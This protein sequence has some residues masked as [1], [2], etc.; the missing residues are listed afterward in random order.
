MK[1]NRNINSIQDADD[2]PIPVCG[3]ATINERV[4]TVQARVVKPVT[5]EPCK[6]PLRLRQPPSYLNYYEVD[7][8]STDVGKYVDYCYCIKTPVTY[9]DA[10]SCPKANQWKC[11]MDN[12]FEML[13]LN[14]T[15]VV[16]ELPTNKSIVGED[17]FII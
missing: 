1:F 9:E 6:Y 10:V 15:F 17:G 8:E 16:T 5:D 2:E 7:A 13:Q 3:E 12:E 14:D 11:A 4:A